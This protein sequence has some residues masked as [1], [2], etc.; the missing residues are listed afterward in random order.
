MDW[1]VQS[2]HG[3]ITGAS[4]SFILFARWPYIKHAFKTLAVLAIMFISRIKAFTD[5]ELFKHILCSHRPAG[6]F[7]H[8]ISHVSGAF[9]MTFTQEN[10][11]D[12]TVLLNLSDEG[13]SLS[14]ICFVSDLNNKTVE[15]RMLIF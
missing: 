3:K 1:T 12:V 7:S 10:F 9:D 11:T 4:G 14:L 8:V 6:L 2:A 15:D 5:F 13:D